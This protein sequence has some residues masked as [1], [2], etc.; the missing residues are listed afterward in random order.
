MLPKTCFLF[1]R[2]YK[3]SRFLDFESMPGTTQFSDPYLYYCLP[4]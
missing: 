3:N 1:I 4:F 2:G